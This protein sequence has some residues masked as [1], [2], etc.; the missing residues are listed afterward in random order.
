MRRVEGVARARRAA[1]GVL[2]GYQNPAALAMPAP[3]LLTRYTLLLQHLCFCTALVAE[4]P[5]YPIEFPGTI[6][7]HRAAGEPTA[8]MAQTPS[9]RPQNG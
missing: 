5:R 6:V 4:L 1:P 9:R 8:T 2:L 3:A 7:L